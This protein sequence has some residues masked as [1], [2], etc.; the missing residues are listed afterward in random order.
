MGKEGKREPDLG[1]RKFTSAPQ[2][3]HAAVTLGD[4][5]TA[6]RIAKLPILT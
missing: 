2:L 3:R 6:F 1:A 5:E 4:V